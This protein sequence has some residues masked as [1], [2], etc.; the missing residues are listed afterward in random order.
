MSTNLS[1]VFSPVKQ[2]NN[3]R[4]ISLHRTRREF[5]NGFNR[6]AQR[7]EAPQC[8]FG[9]ITR[10]EHERAPR[11]NASGFASATIDSARANPASA[12]PFARLSDCILCLGVSKPSICPFLA[13]KR[14]S[15]RCKS[16]RTSERSR[17][18][19]IKLEQK[20]K[21][22]RISRANQLTG[23]RVTARESLQ[24]PGVGIESGMPGLRAT[25]HGSETPRSE[26]A[27][28][29]LRPKDLASCPGIRCLRFQ[30]PPRMH[31]YFHSDPH[32]FYSYVRNDPTDETDPTGMFLW[33]W[34]QAVTV[35]GG[36]AQ[37]R[38]HYGRVVDKVLSTPRGQ[39]LKALIVGPWYWHGNPEEI[40]LQPG[41]K[42][43]TGAVFSPS[44]WTG[45][46]EPTGEIDIDP[47]FHPLIQTTAG[48]IPAND[49][50]VVGHEI[51][52]A[53]TGTQDDGPNQMN[54]VKQNENPIMQELG[55]PAR[56]QYAPP[57]SS[58]GADFSHQN[59]KA[60]TSHV[61]TGSRISTT[62]SCP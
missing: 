6:W 35:T 1:R 62:D 33:P 47:N 56:T 15:W 24:N 2:A 43:D 7:R 34:E 55:Q 26:P 21:L 54:N 13:G 53:A 28:M 11:R 42:Y 41:I 5:P 14:P 25:Q 46:Y 19:K 61:C 57:N 12:A 37:Q 36:T 58:S 9:G 17:L 60:G 29:R 10:R 8:S 45:K 51:G 31:N 22:R 48:A 18:A 44:V 32:L 39:Q 52:H 59:D 38:S 20:S 23:Q 4:S 27:R 50:R 16:P 30:N 3:R 40:K 49:E